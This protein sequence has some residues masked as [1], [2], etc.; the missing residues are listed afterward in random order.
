MP[1]F[2][3]G[4]PW[5]LLTWYC[6]RFPKVGLSCRFGEPE[7]VSLRFY[8]Q[9]F[10][11]AWPHRFHSFGW[12]DDMAL[13]RFPFHSADAA[14]WGVAPTAYRRFVF[15]KRGLSTQKPLHVEGKDMMTFGVQQHMEAMWRREQQLQAQWAATLGKLD[16]R[17]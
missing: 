9:C 2:H 12:V 5:D 13:S 4:D 15:K 3:I 1:V 10:A 7:A 14:T 17:P 8:E 6:E 16:D 11:R